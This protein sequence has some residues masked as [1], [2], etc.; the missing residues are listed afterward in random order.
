M[1]HTF[2]T[3]LYF[4]YI[5][6]LELSGEIY[7][8]LHQ[9]AVAGWGHQQGLYLT[10][11]PKSHPLGWKIL[12]WIYSQ[13]IWILFVG[14]DSCHDILWQCGPGVMKC[15]LLHHPSVNSRPRPSITSITIQWT[16]NSSSSRDHFESSNPLAA[17]RGLQ[18]W[19]SSKVFQNAEIWENK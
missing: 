18:P 9:S 11:N 10:L 5:S 13:R 4:F 19:L 16:S 3:F 17:R 2:Y 14:V 7:R 12:L 6:L 15:G 1:L 8:D